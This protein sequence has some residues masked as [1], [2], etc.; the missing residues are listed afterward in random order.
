MNLS[1][2]VISGSCRPQAAYRPRRCA[3]TAQRSLT[4][5]HGTRN[6]TFQ[7][8]NLQRAPPAQRLDLQRQVL[9]A[10]SVVPI[11]RALEVQA[12]KCAPGLG[13]RGRCGTQNGTHFFGR[14]RILQYL[15]YPIQRF[16]SVSGVNGLTSVLS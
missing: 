8:H 6:S 13:F 4:V 10:H 14:R 11:D 1:S 7:L 5:R 9:K 16:C 3:T 12:K 15:F 2:L